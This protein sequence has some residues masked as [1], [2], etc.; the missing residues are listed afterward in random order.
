MNTWNQRLQAALNHAGMKPA[1]LARAVNAS[2][3]SVSDWTTGITK[4]LKASNAEKVCRVLKIRIEWLL[5]G[6]GPME[7]TTGNYTSKDFK[8]Q[9]IKE[10]STLSPDDKIRA[11]LNGII[12]SATPQ[13]K[14]EILKYAKFVTTQDAAE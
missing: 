13:E 6:K 9:G 7:S 12:E 8:P 14:A 2:T 3:A 4:N 5:Y 11:T 1:E 10:Q